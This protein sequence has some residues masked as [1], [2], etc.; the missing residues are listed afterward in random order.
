MP[1]VKSTITIG[2]DVWICADAFIGPGVMVG[3][4]AIVG[5]RAVALRDV[6]EQMIVSGNPAVAI[7]ERPP[8]S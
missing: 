4:G 5:A 3:R 7:K 1:L 2:D 8:F 6:P